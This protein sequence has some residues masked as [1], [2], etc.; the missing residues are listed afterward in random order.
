[1]DFPGNSHTSRIVGN[2][3]EA[4]TP[5]ADGVS[6]PKKVEKVVQGKVITRKKP[7]GVRFKEMFASGNGDSF[8]EH[9]V[10]N[11]VVPMIKDIIL[12]VIT[13]T[14][15]G[16]K[17]GLEERLFE[18]QPRPSRRSSYS[19]GRPPSVA[20]H[21]MSSSSTTMRRDS[22]TRPPAPRV[23]RRSN[24][25]EDIILASREDGDAVREELE[26]MI[27]SVGHCTLGD[28]YD[29]VGITPKSTDEGWGWTDI[30]RSRINRIP[31]S[32]PPEFLL[33]MPRPIPIEN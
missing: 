26:A 7:L 16:F 21:R 1:M 24:V 15:E 28:L 23:I 17:Q 13:Q 2:D 18:G 32:N 31:G 6:T 9:L 30:S 27:D 3:G 5:E 33:T 8:A 25:V 12:S 4:G 20:Y 22:G 11:V 29:L 19:D 14:A 10:E